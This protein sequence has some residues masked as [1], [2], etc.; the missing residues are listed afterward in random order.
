MRNFGLLLNPS[1]LT[2]PPV[3]MKSFQF[4]LAVIFSTTLAFGAEP[5]TGAADATLS[6]FE[7][8]ELISGPALSADALKGKAVVIEKWGVNCG[9]CLASLPEMEKMWRRNKT[10][11]VLVGAHV[12]SATNEEVRAVVDKNKLSYS[13]TAGVRGPSLNSSIPHA[14]VFD[15]S[16]KMLF[17]GHPTDREFERAVKKATSG[18]KSASSTP[19]GLD[20]LKRN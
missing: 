19:S 5:A 8:G 1:S 9:P 16:G 6:Q 2:L 4:F 18:T 12:Q 7:F 13:I 14:M 10:K 17:N 15:A 3:S 20:A 11:M